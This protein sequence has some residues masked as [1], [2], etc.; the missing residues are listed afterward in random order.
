MWWRHNNSGYTIRLEDAGKYDQ[1][2]VQKNRSYYDNKRE[3]V[4]IPCH[5]VEEFA[6]RIVSSDNMHK[7]KNFIEEA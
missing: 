6:V 5:D 4:A 1:E 7:F 2:M 3:T